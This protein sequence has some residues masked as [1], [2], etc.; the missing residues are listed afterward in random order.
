MEYSAR[1]LWGSSTSTHFAPSVEGR[2]GMTAAT[3]RI[4]LAVT[5][6]GDSKTYSATSV[7]TVCPFG[8]VMGARA[9]SAL[10]VLSTSP[11]SAETKKL[12]VVTLVSFARKAAVSDEANVVPKSSTRSSTATKNAFLHGD[13]SF[14]AWPQ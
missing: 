2:L 11:L 5:S 12:L 14:I 6:L 4:I 9:N 3:W 10:P 13:T 8:E 7:L 1:L